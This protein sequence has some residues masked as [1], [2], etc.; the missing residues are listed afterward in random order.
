MSDLGDG[1]GD[2]V[3][4]ELAPDMGR[5]GP[6][7]GELGVRVVIHPDQYVVLS[8]DSPQVVETSIAILADLARAFDRFGLPHSS[9]AAMNIH[10]GK[11]GK[12]DQLV[13]VIRGLPDN[14][15]SRL[16]LE[17]DE[18][19]YGAAVILEVCRR[20]GVPFV[21]DVHHHVVRE[22]LVSYEDESVPHFVAEARDT[23][24]PP[25]W[26]LVH[27]SNGRD[28]I[29]DRRHHD[30]VTELPSS[31]LTVPWIEVEAKTKEVAIERLRADWPAAD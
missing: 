23:W 15:R 11:A 10:G 22:K 20:A 13:E 31:Y 5:V 24:R 21:F 27:L 1:V 8:S 9:W 17:N 29:Q 30:L 2:S 28:S 4:E 18:H 12:S 19:A 16:T 6:Y 3:L 7:A 26:Q 14:I 25:E